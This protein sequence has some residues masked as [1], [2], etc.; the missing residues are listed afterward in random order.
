M[1]TGGWHFSL[2]GLWPR[3]EEKPDLL[4][5]ADEASLSFKAAAVLVMFKLMKQVSLSRI[6]LVAGLFAAPAP[7][8]G[9]MVSELFDHDRFSGTAEEKKTAPATR[10]GAGGFDATGRIP[11]SQV[12]GQPM[13]QCDFGVSRAGGGSATVVI[14]L[15]NGR[16]RAIFFN[17]GKATSADTSQADGY[18]EFRARR[19]GDLFF[20]RVGEERYEIPEAVIIGG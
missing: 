3:V 13:V 15:P 1:E 17:K 11:C 6:F 7:R 5:S 18:G 10:A 14:T 4:M 2:Y 19:E 20:I 9:A 8:C 12:K 16:K